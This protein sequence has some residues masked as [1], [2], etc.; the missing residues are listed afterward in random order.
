MSSRTALSRHPNPQL[1]VQGWTA[2][3]AGEAC[4]LLYIALVW[5]VAVV[6]VG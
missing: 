2:P 1:V 5:G 4:M 6:I 3:F